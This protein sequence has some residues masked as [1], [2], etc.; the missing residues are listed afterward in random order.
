MPHIVPLSI[1]RISRC[2]KRT[3]AG[4]VTVSG[5][6]ECLDVSPKFDEGHANRSNLN[7]NPLYFLAKNLLQ[8]ILNR[9]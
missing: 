7:C 3:G 6:A 8:V 5:I 4:V 9:S 1:S 2:V